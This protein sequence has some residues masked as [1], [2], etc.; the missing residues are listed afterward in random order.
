MIFFLQ[1]GASIIIMFTTF[2]S[3]DRLELIASKGLD[4][5][6]H[7]LVVSMLRSPVMELVTKG[8]WLEDYKTGVAFD[9]IAVSCQS[10]LRAIHFNKLNLIA[11]F[12]REFINN[13]VPLWHEL[14]AVLAGWHEEIDNNKR[15]RARLYN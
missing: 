5:L 14:D 4:P 3:S 12:S 8:A 11:I 1:G 10:I 13:F 6:F 9:A 7:S 15:I 2:C